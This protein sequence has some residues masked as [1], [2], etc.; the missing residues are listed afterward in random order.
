MIIGIFH[1]GSGTGN[2]LHRYVMTR[3]LALDKGLEFGIACPFN[4][5]GQSFMN[6][7]MG[8]PIP[9]DVNVEYPAGKVIVESDWPLYQEDPFNPNYQ[10]DIKD[11]MI[12]DGEFQGEKYF[13]HRKKEIDEWLKV[14][15]LDMPDDLCIIGFRGGEY[16]FT[17]WFLPQS[18]W[19]DAMKLMIDLGVKKFKVVT[20][21]PDTA[22]RFFPGIEVTHEIGMDWRQVRYAKNLIIANSSFYILPAWLNE[23][24]HVIAP[25]FWAGYNQKKWH[26]GQNEYKNF[27]HI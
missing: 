6:L 1:P 20:D 14:E 10:L 3:V 26:L 7:D 24:A 27:H 8:K 4:F 12:V 23:D 17:N 2:Q 25:R 18:Y 13:E 9:F 15:P 5:K 19:D 16:R 22:A 11:N 21:D